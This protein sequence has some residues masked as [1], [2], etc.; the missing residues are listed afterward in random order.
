[1]NQGEVASYTL[2][3]TPQNG[4]NQQVTV[5]MQSN[6]AGPVMS[7]SPL[8]LNSGNSYTGIATVPTNGLGVGY[9]VLTFNGTDG[10][11]NLQCQANLTVLDRGY[12]DL[13]FDGSDG[14]TTPTPPDGSSGVLS[15]QTRGN[16]NYC[17]PSMAQ[18][19]VPSWTDLGT[20]PPNGNATVTKLQNGQTYIFRIECVTMGGT[21]TP[22]D[23]VE[24]QVGAVQMPTATLQCLGVEGKAP[25]AGPCEVPYNSSV[26]LSWTSAYTNSCSIGPG[27][28]STATSGTQ[29]SPNLTSNV[30]YTLICYGPGGAT[31]PSSVQVNVISNQNYTFALS[32]YSDVQPQGNISTTNL[33][34]LNPVDGFNSPVNMSVVGVSPS[35][36]PIGNI[37]ITG[38]PVNSPYGSSAVAQ[39]ATAGVTPGQYTITFRSNGG[40]ANDPKQLDFVLSVTAAI[41]PQPP[42]NPTVAQGTCGQV[43]VSWNSHASHNSSIEYRVYRRLSGAATWGDAIAVIPYTVSGAYSYQDNNIPAGSYEYRI[44]ASVGSTGSPAYTAVLGPIVPIPCTASLSGTY[45]RI[46]GTGSAPSAYAPCGSSSSIQLP[47]G[48]IYKAGDTVF[49]EICVRS[50]GTLA[51]TNVAIT[52]NLGK[53]LNIENVQLVSSSADCVSGNGSGPYTVN[54]NGNPPG[55]MNPGQTCSVLIRATLKNPGGPASTLHRFTNYARVGASEV[56]TDVNTLPELFSVGGGVPTRTETAP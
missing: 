40:T 47:N 32:S 30:T 5:T 4:Y 38:S 15:W 22:P 11:T 29:N 13:K 26:Q 6:P 12:V 39:I 34:V 25:S 45:K 8:I 31:A 23:T 53:S 10:T 2:F 35:G 19:D 49:F 9:Y 52:E 1:V 55:V 20:L 54:I 7:N 21:P 33:L 24:V 41:A 16:I 46:V 51:L 27:T 17:T 44:S 48:L 43:V 36:L 14:P 42:Q 18:G 37:N 3:A 28:W 56:S 50:S